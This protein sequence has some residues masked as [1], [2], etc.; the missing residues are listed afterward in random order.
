VG[1]KAGR[2]TEAHR[3]RLIRW[4]LRELAETT[5]GL[6]RGGA[7]WTGRDR[8]EL[9]AAWHELRRTIEPWLAEAERRSTEKEA[10]AV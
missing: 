10:G 9:E 8:D 2:F 6:A 5:D 4:L 3:T 7:G 1:E